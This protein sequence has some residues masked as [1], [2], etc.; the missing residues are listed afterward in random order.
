M[1]WEVCE[2]ETLDGLVVAVVEVGGIL[3][4]AP[5]FSWLDESVFILDVV[6]DLVCVAVFFCFFDGALGPSASGK[7]VGGGFSIIAEQVLADSAEL[8]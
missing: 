1:E 3:L 7:V 6:C 5:L 4:D 8:L 2:F